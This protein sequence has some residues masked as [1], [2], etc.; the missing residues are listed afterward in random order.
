MLFMYVI[1]LLSQRGGKP[2][3][4]AMLCAVLTLGSSM[5]FGAEFGRAAVGA[6]LYFVLGLVWFVVLAKL[7]ETIVLW[8]V[9]FL[10]TPFLMSLAV[11]ALDVAMYP[12]AYKVQT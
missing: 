3:I 8:F 2:W 11:L 1:G 5:V 9:V 6:V 12:E 10:P 4:L 7:S